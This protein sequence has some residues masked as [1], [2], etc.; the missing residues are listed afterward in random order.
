M[1]RA[2]VEEKKRTWAAALLSPFRSY[3]GTKIDE[4]EK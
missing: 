2:G 1:G 4:R 3:L